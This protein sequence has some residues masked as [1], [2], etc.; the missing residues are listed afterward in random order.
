MALIPPILFAGSI[1]FIIP[2]C[3]IAGTRI[4]KRLF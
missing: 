4:A 2:F 1:A 3:W